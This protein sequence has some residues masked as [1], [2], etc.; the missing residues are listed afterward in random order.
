MKF[1]RHLPIILIVLLVVSCE[2]KTLLRSK[3]KY[4]SDLQGYWRPI[5]GTS[6]YG[7]S[8]YPQNIQWVFSDGSVKVVKI[9]SNGTDS[10]LDNG[11]YAI[12]TKIDQSYLTI[13]GFTSNYYDTIYGF[14][15]K[16]TLIQLDADILDILGKPNGG[17]QVEIEFEKQ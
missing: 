8:V 13:S 5:K 12:D 4:D 9:N 10:I 14:N 16:W 7:T 15:I 11:S 1:F 17:G 3:K 2:S 6:I